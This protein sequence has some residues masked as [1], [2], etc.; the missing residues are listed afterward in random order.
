MVAQPPRPVV[1]PAHARPPQPAPAARPLVATSGAQSRPGYDPMG[2]QGAKVASNP[3]YVPHGAAGAPP[4]ATAPA[5]AGPRALVSVTDHD[6]REAVDRLSIQPPL[7]DQELQAIAAAFYRCVVGANQVVFGQGERA[8]TAYLLESGLARMEFAAPGRPV[9]AVG[10]VKAGDIIGEG[11]LVGGDS[12]AVTVAAG[13]E[14]VFFAVGAGQFGELQRHAPAVAVRFLA[15]AAQQQVRRLR[16]DARKIDAFAAHVLG[17]AQPAAVAPEPAAPATK[18]GKLFQRI[19][20][21]G[22]EE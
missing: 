12:H 17:I 4:L 11:S 5:G 6:F 3:A 8:D 16:G 10:S 19:A 7:G 18:L 20:G 2:G 22:K 9:E 15:V 1:D 14:C 13:T 21:G